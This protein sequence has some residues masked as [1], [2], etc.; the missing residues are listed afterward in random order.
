[1]A[2]VYEAPRSGAGRDLQP[3]HEALVEIRRP[4]VCA[5]HE[6]VPAAA[7]WRVDD[8]SLGAGLGIDPREESPNATNPHAGGIGPHRTERARGQAL[9]G[10]RRGERR[11]IETQEILHSRDPDTAL[12]RAEL[13]RPRDLHVSGHGR[14]SRVDPE[15]AVRTFADDVDDV[16]GGAEVVAR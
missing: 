8:A 11:W 15:D 13:D 7:E 14:G 2:A 5:I 9:D 1:M 12:R 10:Q 16:C 3:Q 4:Q 6:D